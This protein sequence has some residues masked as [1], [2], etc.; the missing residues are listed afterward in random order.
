MLPQ[1]IIKYIGGGVRVDPS[2]IAGRRPACN[3][4]WSLA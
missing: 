1:G 4:P 3:K 2:H